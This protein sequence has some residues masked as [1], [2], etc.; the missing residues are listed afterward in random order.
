M[1]IA[2]GSPNATATAG[3]TSAEGVE[4]QG[5]SGKIGALIPSDMPGSCNDC[6]LARHPPGLPVA[7]YCTTLQDVN[8][9]N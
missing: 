8:P 1:P 6:A 3:V 2:Q 9:D 5:I 7:A 4:G